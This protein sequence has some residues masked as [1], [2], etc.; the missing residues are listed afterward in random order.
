[1]SLCPAGLPSTL[2]LKLCLGADRVPISANV[3]TSGKQVGLRARGHG[4]RDR[5]RVPLHLSPG[6]V[7]VPTAGLKHVMY[8]SEILP[9][10]SPKCILGLP[11]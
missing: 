2:S 4:V 1:M 5:W 6:R 10:L 11:W 7:G 8:T 9:Y 3:L